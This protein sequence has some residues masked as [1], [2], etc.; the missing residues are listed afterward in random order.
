MK[1]VLS[2]HNR[3]TLVDLFIHEFN[4]KSLLAFTLLNREREPRAAIHADTDAV[5]LFSCVSHKVEFC[6]FFKISDLCSESM[7]CNKIS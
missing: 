4:S 7:Q 3:A 1:Q 6:S 5:V 2:M